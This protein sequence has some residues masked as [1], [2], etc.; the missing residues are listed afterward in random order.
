[1]DL[2]FDGAGEGEFCCFFGAVGEHGFVEVGGGDVAV[3]AGDFCEGESEVA[4]AAGAVEDFV[5]GFDAAHFDGFCAP[6]VVGPEGKDGVDGVVA[7][8]DAGEHVVDF[9]AHFLVRWVVGG[10][11]GCCEVFRFKIS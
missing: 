9:L 8:G 1:M 5:A 4:G 11:S 7:G 2:P 10:W 6:A 3:C